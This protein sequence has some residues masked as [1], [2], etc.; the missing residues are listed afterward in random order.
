MNRK[1]RQGKAKKPVPV[2][3]TDQ[4]PEDILVVVEYKDDYHPYSFFELC[5]LGKTKAQICAQWKITRHELYD[6][7]GKHPEFKRAVQKGREAFEAYWNEFHSQIN[8]G[9]RKTSAATF[10][11]FLKNKLGYGDEPTNDWVDDDEF[12]IE[13]VLDK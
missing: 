11:F 9:E 13:W 8:R 12:E 10:I 6:W 1:S 2:I 4:D 5:S 7:I 3:F